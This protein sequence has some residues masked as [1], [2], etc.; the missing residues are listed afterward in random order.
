LL[1]QARTIN[2]Q[3]TLAT[4]WSPPGWMKTGDTMNGGRLKAGAYQQL[5]GYFAK[6][7][8]AY[9]AAG[10]PVRYVTPRT[11]RCTTHRTTRAWA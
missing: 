5:A 4:P 1:K 6:F 3:L 10:V 2:P 8:K 9:E 11:S 7:L